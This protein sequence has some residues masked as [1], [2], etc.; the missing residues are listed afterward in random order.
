MWKPIKHTVQDCPLAVGDGRFVE[1]NDLLAMDHIT[2]DYVGEAYVLMERHGKYKWY[3][4]DGQSVDEM[5]VFKTYDSRPDEHGAKYCRH[6]AFRRGVVP[7]G[8]PRESIE[9]RAL[10][11]SV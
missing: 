10:V 6:A 9:V 3:Y 5:L 4:L 2:R 11:F 1:T 7:D 8:P